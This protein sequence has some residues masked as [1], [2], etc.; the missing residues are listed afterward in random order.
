MTS[1][2]PGFRELLGRGQKQCKCGG[3]LSSGHDISHCALEHTTTAVTLSGPAQ[4]FSHL[5]HKGLWETRAAP[6]LAGEL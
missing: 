1:S 2:P 3:M 4:N 5:F 6:P